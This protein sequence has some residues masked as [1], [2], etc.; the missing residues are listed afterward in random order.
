[1]RLKNYIE[2]GAEKAGSLTSLGKL[3]DLS[4]PQISATKAGKRALPAMAVV[5][6]ADYIQE[7]VKNVIAANE[8]ITEK[9]EEKIRYWNSIMQ[10]ASGAMAMVLLAVTFIVTPT[11]SEAAQTLKNDNSMICIM[12]NC[13]SNF[14]KINATVNARGSVLA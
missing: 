3:L 8:L 6:L 12:L 14:F 1:M 7:D 10:K 13:L 11:P 4:Q 9:K 2:I 5:K